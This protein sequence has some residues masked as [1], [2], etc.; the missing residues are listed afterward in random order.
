M[1]NVPNIGL[2]IKVSPLLSLIDEFSY[3][4]YHST[5]YD[6]GFTFVINLSWNWTNS[7]FVPPQFIADALHLSTE[8]TPTEKWINAAPNSTPTRFRHYNEDIYFL[9]NCKGFIIFTLPLSSIIFIILWKIY[10]KIT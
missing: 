9:N 4:V 1:V 5:P 10:H 6:K 8:S 3:F 2:F 7:K